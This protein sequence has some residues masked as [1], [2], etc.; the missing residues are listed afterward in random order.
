MSACTERSRPQPA[1]GPPNILL[2]SIDS[3]RADHLGTYGYDKPTSPFIDELAREGL[4]FETAVSSTSWT[5]PAHAALFTGLADTAHAV[6]TPKSRLAANYE[7]MAEVLSENG[8]ETLAFY[9]G[10]F[11]HPDFGLAQGFD[12]YIDCTSFKVGDG[13]PRKRHGASHRDVT[14][15]ILLANA[16]REIGALG[17]D[18]FF[19]FLHMWDVHYDLIPPEN[20]RLMFDG[21]YAGDFDGRSYRHH[22]GFTAGMNDADFNHVLALY[23][24]EIRYTDDTLA[25][26]VALL[27]DA[28]R[29]DN[30]IIAVVSDHGD[31]F[32][33]HNGK[34]HRHTLFQELIHIPLVVWMPGR[35]SSGRVDTPVSLTDVAPT[36]LDFV[37]IRP[38][39]GAT[40]RSLTAALDGGILDV[41]P[42]LSELTA[43]PK[44]PD[45]SALLLGTDKIVVDHKRA[46]AVYYDLAADPRELHPV[47]AER[48]DKAGPLLMTL[49][50]L[51][52]R[53]T[54]IR[55]EHTSAGDLELDDEM[56]DQLGRLGYLD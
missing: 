55:A 49:M 34:G 21:D 40:G 44:A 5:L 2:V 43:P 8:Y 18:P 4:V 27:D 47:A 15:P 42:V 50:K 48:A 11:L 24:G 30:T 35:I 14:N 36:L 39:S 56:R 54:A 51:K 6:G 12:R 45:L 10:P 13:D 9:S 23:D 37:G 1:T 33:E 22:A 19:M 26:I 25:K 41:Q 17:S 3:L 16:E 7:T 32:L 28:G 31:E 29:L 46:K 53:A 38:I 52:K 20:Y